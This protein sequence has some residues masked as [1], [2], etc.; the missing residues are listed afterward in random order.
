MEIPAGILTDPSATLT[1]Q[2]RSK[3]FPYP[4]CPNSPETEP[5]FA[6]LKLLTGPPHA[7]ETHAYREQKQTEVCP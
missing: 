7:T 1:Y 2:E 4:K 5:D 3:C 6:P